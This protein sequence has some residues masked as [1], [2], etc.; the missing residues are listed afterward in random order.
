MTGPQKAP[1]S[2]VAPVMQFLPVTDVQ[3]STRFYRD[4]LGFSVAREPSADYGVR[5][6]GEVSRGAARLQFTPAEEGSA[7]RVLFLESADVD[8]EHAALRQR[9]AAPSAIERVN[10]IKMRMFEVRDSDGHVLWFGESFHAPTEAPEQHMLRQVMPEIP[11]SDVA[12]GV[13]HYCDVLGFKVNYQQHDLGV[14]DR[15]HVRVLLTARQPVHRGIACAYF[16]VE[17]ADALHQEL[18]RSGALVQGVPVSQ[19]WGL[20]DF[21]VQDPEGNIL[22]FGQPF[23]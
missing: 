22:T 23:E 13:R 2:I 17:N 10:W 15:D 9:D 1:P 11:L 21:S 6:L 20:R 4:V 18:R 3:R 8:A 7:R 12:A 16:Y 19:P 5:A 14:L